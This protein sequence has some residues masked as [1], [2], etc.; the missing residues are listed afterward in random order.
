MYIFSREGVFIGMK[1]FS[2]YAHF[3]LL[4]PHLE[5]NTLGTYDTLGNYVSCFS[6]AH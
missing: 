4:G 3:G 2:K 1:Y 6:F 5:R